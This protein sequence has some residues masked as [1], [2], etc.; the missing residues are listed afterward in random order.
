MRCRTCKYSLWNLAARTCPECGDPFAPS[1]YHFRPNSV[2]FRC[3][4]CAQPYYGTDP[5]G[6]LSPRSF[7][8]VSCHKPV[9]M[10]LMILVPAP[11][12]DPDR[13]VLD[14]QAWIDRRQIGRRRA[15]W[16]TAMMG[17]FNPVELARC[18]PD[19]ARSGAAWKFTAINL[20]IVIGLTYLLVVAFGLIGAFIAMS[21]G[22][23]GAS[24]LLMVVA[25]YGAFFAALYILQLLLVAVWIGVT[26]VFLKVTGGA[27]RPMRATSL[28]LL[29]TSGAYL[30]NIIP[31]VNYISWL[32]WPITAGVM[33]KD[34]QGVSAWRA[35]T[36]TLLTPVLIVVG[37][38]AAYAAFIAW[39]M[40]FA[41]PANMNA[42]LNSARATTAAAA[43]IQHQ[44]V[45]GSGPDH[46]LQLVADGTLS[47][48]MMSMGGASTPTSAIPAGDTTL[49]QFLLLSPSEQ[50][51]I[52]LA[53]ANALPDNVTA[54]RLG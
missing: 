10:D 22:G 50:N 2:E 47:Q 12:V 42:S 9:G 40:S 53:A 20:A 28:S 27:P 54:H 15:W 16:K 6:H 52:A 18:T 37:F 13:A 45:T 49:D 31:C 23:G 44:A 25:I 51:A 35:V 48:Y 46:A 29:Y 19:D 24:I 17:M 43:V 4:H 39:M 1:D 33:L 7:A 34:M 5:Q 38:I 30:P 14:E 11:G 32:W 3:P 21:S 41:S 26:H 36:A 8:C